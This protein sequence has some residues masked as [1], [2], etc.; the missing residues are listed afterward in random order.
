M[1][2]V[3]MD[4]TSG[5]SSLDPAHHT[6]CSQHA[7]TSPSNITSDSITT[8]ITDVV[9]VA[10]NEAVMV[11]NAVITDQVLDTM[12]KINNISC[13]ASNITTASTT[14]N[15]DT[16]SV[17]VA[18]T[19]TAKAT[20]DASNTAS[21]KLTIIRSDITDKFS[22]ITSTQSII[23]DAMDIEDSFTYAAQ[24]TT[25]ISQATTQ[26][27]ADRSTHQATTVTHQAT[28]D[29]HKVIVDM[30]QTTVDM[31]QAT[32][33]THQAAMDTHQATTDTHQATVN[34]HQAIVDT[35]QATT[36]THQATVNMH[37]A[38]EDTHQAA[39]NTHQADMDTHQATGDMHQA[40]VNTHQAAMDTHQ[41]TKD[42]HQTTVDMHQ[43]IVDTHQAT[44]HTHQG[45]VNTHQATTDTHQAAVDTHQATVD[46][47]KTTVD[48]HQ[49]ITDTHH[50]TVDTTQAAMGMIQA[51]AGTTQAATDT[52][53]TTI[54]SVIMPINTTSITAASI[55]AETFTATKHTVSHQRDKVAVVRERAHANTAPVIVPSIGSAASTVPV[56]TDKEITVNKASQPTHPRPVMG[57]KTYSASMSPQIVAGV[58]IPLSPIN[59]QHTLQ[60]NCTPMEDDN[61]VECLGSSTSKE[62]I[63]STS[64]ALSLLTCYGMSDSEDDCDVDDNMETNCDNVANEVETIETAVN[65]ASNAS[66]EFPFENTVPTLNQQALPKVNGDDCTIVGVMEQNIN[67]RTET[68]NS[69]SETSELCITEP[70][71]YRYVIDV[72]SDSEDSEND[73]SLSSSSSSLSSSSSESDSSSDESEE[74]PI[75]FKRE[76]ITLDKEK[77]ELQKKRSSRRKL[78]TTGELLIEDLPPIDDLHISVPEEKAKPIG[79]ILNIV[80]QQVVV[81]A[82]T[83]IP[84]IDLD[85]VLFL[86]HGQRTLGHV[87]DVFGPV[88]E[89]FYVVRFN[90]AEHVKD[91]KIEKGDLVYFAPSTEHTNYVLVND[92][93]RMKGTDASGLA[94]NELPASEVQ[95]FSDDEEEVTILRGD[96]QN[97]YTSSTNE[98][99]PQTKRCRGQAHVQF[100]G[101]EFRNENGNVNPFRRRI[102]VSRAPT[103]FGHP[104][105]MHPRFGPHRSS[106]FP[107]T[108]PDYNQCSPNFQQA[109]RRPQNPGAFEPRS[110]S[111]LQNQVQV[112][113]NQG[114][115]VISNK[116]HGYHNGPPPDTAAWPQSPH[117]R[118]GGPPQFNSPSEH[119]LHGLSGLP[120][121]PPSSLDN[122]FNLGSPLRCYDEVMQSSEVECVGDLN[123]GWY[124]QHDVTHPMPLSSEQYTPSALAH[125]KVPPPPPD[126][127]FQTY[128]NMS[129]PHIMQR[130][131]GMPP[132]PPPPPSP[133]SMPP[134]PPPPPHSM[135]P[136]PLPHSMP[137]PPPP[138]SM[139]PPPPPPSHSMPPPPP[140]HSMQRPPSHSMPPPPPPSHSMPP[141]SHSMPPPPH[142]MLPSSHSVPPPNPPSPHSITPPSHNM[143]PP[144]S[145]S[146]LPLSLYSMTPPHNMPPPSLVHHLSSSHHQSPT[147]PLHVQFDIT[148]A[149][150]PMPPA[151]F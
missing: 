129:L 21:N 133:Q 126:N 46:A 53:Q 36:D 84:P 70:S 117:Y 111:N 48:A 56:I 58:S 33:D 97:Q 17:T 137:P 40:A 96:K 112:A 134:P 75:D 144:H 15:K 68:I 89:P 132:P 26:P 151:S 99:Q 80:E 148:R 119:F 65:V 34:M 37:Q 103:R 145:M 106:L 138:H 24:A 93:M 83:N 10:T 57:E 101:R 108:R 102:M 105:T 125:S 120:C 63:T 11:P 22:G 114:M 41:A 92:L 44:A 79:L 60:T 8:K 49:A 4:A 2:I 128:Q 5:S 62:R 147:P 30:H 1:G 98:F 47:P 13:L 118:F 122:S 121:P 19:V 141:P 116:V 77:C 7:D 74:S 64:N 95:D 42:T 149:P 100:H 76:K 66:F 87:F 50:A 54:V 140:P 59:I 115:S 113:G 16:L 38:T 52:T 27:E 104:S 61:A 25:D 20:S 39:V 78:L 143:N 94:G 67:C 139:P 142:S 72:G 109:Q 71:S 127:L 32:V 88:Q 31:H 18:N 107:I 81:A 91:Q 73:S 43:A 136:P 86:D 35:H 23:M 55:T 45:A 90:S 150:P 146:Q 12:H 130:S 110:F 29:T 85:T 69:G 135:P 14:S 6:I 28:M 9:F 51:T 123:R 3:K 82:F 124:A 131:H